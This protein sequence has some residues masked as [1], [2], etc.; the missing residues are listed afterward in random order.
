MQQT[1]AQTIPIIHG[2]SDDVYHGWGILQKRCISKVGSNC[3]HQAKGPQGAPII[4]T[5][6]PLVLSRIRDNA[7]WGLRIR[8]SGYHLEWWF[9][10]TVCWHIRPL[11]QPAVPA[12]HSLNVFTLAP[13]YRGTVVCKGSCAIYFKQVQKNNHTAVIK[14]NQIKHIIQTMKR[15]KI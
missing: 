11:R 7:H 10:T 4:G 3:S 6:P 1:Y 14:A 8:D 15:V 2:Q 5:H 9:L 12:T 13:G